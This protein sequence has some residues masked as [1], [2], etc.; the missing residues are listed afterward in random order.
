[1]RKL[2]VTF[3]FVWTAFMLQCGSFHP[4]AQTAGP[5]GPTGPQGPAGP[6]GP[7][8]PAGPMG[9]QGPQGA[10]GPAGPQGSIGSTG[11]QGATGAQGP[12]GSQGPQ[13][14]PGPQIILTGWCGV[15]TTANPPVGL[16]GAGP[17]GCFNGYTAAGLAP[18]GGETALLPIPSA[19]TLKNLT[20]AATGYVVPMG[21]PFNFAVSIQVFVNGVATP[22][23]CI[24]TA[25]VPAVPCSDN[26]HTVAVLAGDLIAVQMSTASSLTATAGLSMYM[27][28]EKQ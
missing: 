16:F 11:P 6:T 23:A 27:A 3:L 13:G 22:L 10:Q 8:G 1:M 28:L 26:A 2:I 7:Q 24:V 14:P 15:N 19:G 25:S 4:Q 9:L 20:V 17:N 5:Q 18:G 12:A 21:N